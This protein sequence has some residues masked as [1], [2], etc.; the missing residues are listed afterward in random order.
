MLDN[1]HEH[2]PKVIDKYLNMIVLE[3]NK[4]NSKINI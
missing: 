4:N 3:C 1:V 2:E